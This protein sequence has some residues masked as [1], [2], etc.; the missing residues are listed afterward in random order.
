MLPATLPHAWDV[1]DIN[2]VVLCL[3]GDCLHL[4]QHLGFLLSQMRWEI[5]QECKGLG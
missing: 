1:F 2:Q 4:G 3:G 5:G